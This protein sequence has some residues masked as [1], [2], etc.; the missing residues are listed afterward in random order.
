MQR[1]HDALLGLVPQVIWDSKYFWQRGMR[2][3][4]DCDVWG[5][6][7]YIVQIMIPMLKEMKRISHGHPGNITAE[8]WDEELDIMTKGFEA[9]ERMLDFSKYPDGDWVK[10]YNKDEKIFKKNMKVFISRFF[11]L[12]D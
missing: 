8:K 12:W 4:A 7:S 1:I 2:G 6:D 5:I 10:S 3:Y 11:D 9:A